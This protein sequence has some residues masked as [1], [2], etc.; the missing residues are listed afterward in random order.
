[1]ARKPQK[2]YELT[3]EL[4]PLIAEVKKRWEDG[5]RDA[6]IGGAWMLGVKPDKDG[7]LVLGKL[8]RCSELEKRMTPLDAIVLINRT[9]FDRLTPALKLALVHHEM[10]HLAA[11]EDKHGEQ[12]VD[13]HGE[14]KWRG[15]KH[16]LE[17]FKEVVQNHGAYVSDIATFA[18]ALIKRD[19]NLSLF[20]GER[21]ANAETPVAV[22][23]ITLSKS[24]TLTPVAHFPEPFEA[25]P[26]R[27]LVTGRGKKKAAAG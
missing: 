2:R 17:E 9:Y 20:D 23:T 12:M 27:K 4:D 16:D 3:T 11:M 10:C 14:R 19:P 22:N 25:A 13:G 24:V 1:M 8:K 15:V 6:R 26:N 18:E 21:N 7:H 5:L